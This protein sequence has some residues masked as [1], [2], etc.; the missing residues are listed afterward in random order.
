MSFAN[1]FDV[2]TQIQII[3]DKQLECIRT[4]KKYQ[5]K[6]GSNLVMKKALIN[7]RYASSMTTYIFNSDSSSVEDKNR[8]LIMYVEWHNIMRKYIE[9]NEKE[10]LRIIWKRVF[11]DYIYLLDC[12]GDEYKE[13]FIY[14]IFK[15]TAQLKK[16]GVKLLEPL[17]RDTVAV[18]KYKYHSE[19]IKDLLKG[20]K[21]NQYILPTKT[22]EDKM[23]KFGWFGGIDTRTHQDVNGY[24]DIFLEFFVKRDAQYLP[25][26]QKKII[27]TDKVEI[28]E[29]AIRKKVIDS[30][31]RDEL[32]EYALKMGCANV[33]TELIL[34]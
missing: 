13:K 18:G 6:P 8:A 17:I 16:Q 31:A 19:E 26:L 3:L 34:L 32:L 20:G 10:I 9:K 24:F 30:K 28:V 23:D 22:I 27:D 33:V 7:N 15:T 5:D 25:N 14:E 2:E 21:R 1:I 11:D 29:K 4:I 12:I